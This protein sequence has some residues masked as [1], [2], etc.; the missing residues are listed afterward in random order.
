MLKPPGARERP[1]GKTRPDQY[2][3][4]VALA[5]DAALPDEVRAAAANSGVW[6]GEICALGAL[7]GADLAKAFA[8]PAIPG[9]P[10]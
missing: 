8:D 7:L 10:P 6:R 5:S 3:A 4:V 2:P 9:L 1:S